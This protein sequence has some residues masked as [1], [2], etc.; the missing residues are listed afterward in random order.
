MDAARLMGRFPLCI[1]CGVYTDHLQTPTAVSAKRAEKAPEID[2]DILT[3]DTSLL[4][5]DN[6]R[7]PKQ[8]AQKSESGPSRE[9][10]TKPRDRSSRSSQSDRS[11][12]PGSS[13]DR[14]A[15]SDRAAQSQAQRSAQGDRKPRAG[16]AQRAASRAA[17]SASPGV[18]MQVDNRPRG[19]QVVESVE[20]DTSFKAL[21]GGASLL[22]LGAARRAQGRG[23]VE[24]SDWAVRRGMKPDQGEFSSL[25]VGRR[26][27]Q[28]H[29]D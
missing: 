18:D 22:G 13:G 5:P 20:F 6:Q 11:D 26:S 12:R 24:K 4:E 7:R 19:K 23:V 16:A 8:T 2:L 29:S 27:D 1:L 14:A 17:P 25:Y 28:A 3:Q 21:F 10:S 9:R 15:R